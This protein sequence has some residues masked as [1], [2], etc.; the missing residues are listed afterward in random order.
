M[1]RRHEL[2]FHC[3]RVWNGPG[4]YKYLPDTSVVSQTSES[5]WYTKTQYPRTGRFLA[6][7]KMT[8]FLSE[9]S[10]LLES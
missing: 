10:T 9:A 4:G 5:L 6:L 7:F 3:A 2:D 8:S 1:P